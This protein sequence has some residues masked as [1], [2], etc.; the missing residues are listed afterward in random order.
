MNKIV[1]FGATALLLAS[2][3][4]YAHHP[5]ADMVD[6]DIYA[7]IEDNISDVH[8]AM[9]FDD[10]GGDTSDMGAGMQSRGGDI[11]NI[12]AE[13]GGNLQ[14]I[15]SAME[16]VQEMSSMADGVPAGPMGNQR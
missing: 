9:T 1:Q 10:M 4:S 5:A 8:L 11:D 3:N 6:A 13:I 15:G 7:M 14:D 16:T 12:S 2:A